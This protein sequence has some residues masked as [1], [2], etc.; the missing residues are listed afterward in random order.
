MR[1]QESWAGSQAAALSS[2]EEDRPE[3]DHSRNL[4]CGPLTSCPIPGITSAGEPASL[5][6]LKVLEN[7]NGYQVAHLRGLR[8]PGMVN[9]AGERLR[10]C[11]STAPGRAMEP[12]RRRARSPEKPTSAPG[13]RRLSADI[14]TQA[15][16]FPGQRPGQVSTQVSSPSARNRGRCKCSHCRITQSCLN[17][18]SVD[19]TLF[20]RST[21]IHK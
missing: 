16:S 12:P 18:I 17:V 1:K 11:R 21:F 10:A 4:S 8:A 6:N 19:R 3:G 15:Q 2:A 13:P 14:Q 9:L 7:W 20:T 5:L